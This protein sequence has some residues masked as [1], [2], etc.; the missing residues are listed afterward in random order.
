MRAFVVIVFLFLFLKFKRLVIII[1]VIIIIIILCSWLKRFI[2]EGIRGGGVDEVFLFYFLKMCICHRNVGRPA[3][4]LML[5]A[6]SRLHD[7]TIF[8]ALRQFFKWKFRFYFIFSLFLK[9]KTKMK[10]ILLSLIFFKKHFATPPPEFTPLCA[11]LVLVLTVYDTRTITVQCISS[12]FFFKEEG[13][14]DQ[15]LLCSITW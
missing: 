11:L 14:Q 1:I 5:T 13:A 10:I 15:V 4:S 3:E 6:T 7:T 12:F 9:K 2:M 8:K